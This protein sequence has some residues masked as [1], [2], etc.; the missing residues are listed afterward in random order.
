MDVQMPEMDGLQATAAIRVGERQTGRHIPIIAMT[1]HAMKEDRQ[2]CLDAGMDE[3]VSKPIQDETLTQA[4]E[5]CVPSSGSIA[6]AS[7]ASGPG[8]VRSSQEPAIA[9]VPRS[10]VGPDLSPCPGVPQRPPVPI[11]KAGKPRVL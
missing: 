5:H 9:H 8:A 4:I 11:G 6:V 7:T 10:S 3:Y 2:R 1:A